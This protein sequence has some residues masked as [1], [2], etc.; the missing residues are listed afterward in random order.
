MSK[1]ARIEEL[2]R[3]VSYLVDKIG[4]LEDRL[5]DTHR[6]VSYLEEMVRHYIALYEQNK[7]TTTPTI[8]PYPPYP[9]G[10]GTPLPD[11]PY[12]VT[13]TAI[14]TRPGKSSDTRRRYQAHGYRQR[15][16]MRGIIYQMRR[17]PNSR[18]ASKTVKHD[19]I[20]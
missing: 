1:K 4:I 19:T 13:L 9:L 17:L 20:L 14:R 15:T 5:D 16:M 2:E 12:R 6:E 3:R 11:P 10:T 18:S 7:T 8:V